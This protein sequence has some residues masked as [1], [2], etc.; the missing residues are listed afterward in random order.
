[1]QSFIILKTAIFSAS[2]STLIFTSLLAY[3]H[4]TSAQEQ[5]SIV[6]VISV[7]TSKTAQAINQT[8]ASI[9]AVLADEIELISAQHIS[10]VLDSAPGIWISR[11]NGQEHLTAIRSPVLTG[12]GSCGAFFM[13]LDGISIR[14]PGFCNSNQLF[15]INYEQAARIDVLRSP[16]STLYGSNALHGVINV[17][18]ADAFENDSNIA[19]LQFGANDFARISNSYGQVNEKSAWRS[20]VNLTQENG[21]QFQ[22]GYDQQKMTHI[23]QTRGDVW[24]TKSVLDV[25]NLNQ[26]TAGFI[27]GFESYKDSQ[28][29]R[30]N[31]NPE[32][33]RDAKSLRAY[34]A[35]SKTDDSG[36]LTLTP[37]LR[38]NKMAFLQHFL[39]WQGLEENR[40]TSLGLQSQYSY[41]WQDIDWVS[42]ADIDLTRGS[43]LETQQEDFSP[44]VPKGIH[45]DY[46]VNAYQL[47]A[48]TKG[49]W[50][51]N[52][53]IVRAGVR[54]E[55]NQYNYTNNAGSPSACAPDVEVCRFSRPDSQNLSFNALSPSINVQYLMSTNTSLYA[56][57]SQ[58]FRAPQAT[59]L[60]RLQNN[61]QITDINNENM[62]AYEAGIRYS[63][64]TTNLHIAG[65]SMRK[66]DAI[67]QN[68][69]RQNVSGAITQHEGLE[70]ELR[71][72]LNADWQFSGH[73]S[74][75]Q[76]TYENETTLVRTS[77]I[78]NTIDTAPK[79]LSNLNISYSPN[80]QLTAQLSWQYLSEYYLNPENTA[81]YEG[82]QLLDVNIR[83][84]LAQQ[85][86]L[87]VHVLNLT[88]E[89][90][91]ERADF[92]FGSYRYFVGQPR[93]AF[94]NLVWSY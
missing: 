8:P 76:H 29:R 35:F 17:V 66:K 13:G 91:A 55:R 27:R 23:Y 50:Q 86:S 94:I 63:N 33:Y 26:E 36:S 67:F 74:W 77:I 73:I 53:W 2:V 34:T 84:Q 75:S 59:E 4:P 49:R 22:S 20:L 37:Y 88:D 1:M 65:F 54:L 41:R 18:T 43:L 56:K 61:Q 14:A 57:Y 92:A 93:R 12:A 6:E 10:Q 79:W 32:A 85:I 60:F 72:Q 30:S 69:D 52:N 68:S 25:S 45:Y 19:G 51:H 89:E 11:G 28:I 78:N 62:N 44:S 9:S 48:Y 39:P 31:P 80:A 46:D 47:S 87:R 58:G 70:V 3:S 90:Y 16:A 82:H 83:Y 7:T 64:P 24:D 40:H 21:F 38:W 5:S 71:Q 81:E 15:D 42:G